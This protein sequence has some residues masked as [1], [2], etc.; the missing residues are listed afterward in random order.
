MTTARI[1]GTYVPLVNVLVKRGAEPFLGEWALPG[2]FVDEGQHLQP[3]SIVGG[4]HGVSRLHTGLIDVT[5]RPLICPDG[6]NGTEHHDADEKDR[7]GQCA[8]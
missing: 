8:E 5:H 6:G 3:L 2:G 7:Q 4:W 1:A